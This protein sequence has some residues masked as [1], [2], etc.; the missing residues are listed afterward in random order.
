MMCY[1]TTVVADFAGKSIGKLPELRS[2][3][4]K[5]RNSW[6]DAPEEDDFVAGT[7]RTRESFHQ[8]RSMRLQY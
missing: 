7:A 4:D 6:S 2:M 3:A 8:V 1:P 5:N